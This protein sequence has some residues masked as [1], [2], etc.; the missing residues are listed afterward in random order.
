MGNYTI[1]RECTGGDCSSAEHSFD[2]DASAIEHAAGA[3]AGARVLVWRE[4]TVIS[5]LD[6]SIA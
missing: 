2:D 3:A 1:V 5:Y 4:D 6:H